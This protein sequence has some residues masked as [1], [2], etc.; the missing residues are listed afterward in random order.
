MPTCSVLTCPA[1]AGGMHRFPEDTAMRQR[2]IEFC[3]LGGA[4]W[5]P[6]AASKV[7]SHHFLS[8]DM[9]VSGRVK[10]KRV[11]QLLGSKRS[12]L[13][14]TGS[15]LAVSDRSFSQPL[16]AFFGILQ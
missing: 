2:W 8:A 7:C 12:S 5:V 11:P 6:L 15:Y 1:R 3:G 4:R 9:T 10:P 14:L 13:S 16:S